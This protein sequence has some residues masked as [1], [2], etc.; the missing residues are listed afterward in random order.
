[1]K[2][3][4]D[5]LAAV[6]T[7]AVE[8]YET[9]QG[10]VAQRFTEAQREAYKPRSEEFNDTFYAK[11]LGT[12]GIILRFRTDSPWLKLAV[13][14]ERSSSRKYFSVD[15][16]AD[17]ERVGSLDNFQEPETGTD[18]TQMDVPMGDFAGEF[19]L[20]AGEKTVYIYLP[21]SVQ[22][23]ITSLELADGAA[24]IPVKYEKHLLAFGDSI[25]HGYDALRNSNKYITRLAE[26]LGMEEH[27]KAIGGE[28]FW[29]ALAAMAD[30]FTPDLITVA[31]GT[32]DWRHFSYDVVK[33]NCEG[34]FRNLRKTYPN[35]PIVAVTPIWRADHESKEQPF[36]P[37]PLVGQMI[38]QIVA[39]LDN[40]YVVEGWDLVP[41]DTN[42]F[43]DLRL[44]PNDAGFV[45]YAR[46]LLA[47]FPDELK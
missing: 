9:Q 1:M 28:V 2:L 44:H 38:R 25:T 45:H 20:G 46:N 23:V 18:Y 8:L 33:A 32:N 4:F 39:E 29:P 11:T 3:T 7:G 26:S 19:P 42:L 27:N 40:A 34:F 21:W 30:P 37:F 16:V 43:G 35:T 10:F 22:C 17:G 15:V 24:V 47:A 36:G 31:Y 14:V 13:H 6:T 5:Q 12:S 41:M